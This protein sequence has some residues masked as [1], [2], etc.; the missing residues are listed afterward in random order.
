[1]SMTDPFVPAPLGDESGTIPAADPGRG[2]PDTSEGFGVAGEE[3]DIAEPD[4]AEPD[5][6]GSGDARAEVDP[7]LGPLGS[8]GDAADPPFR[9]P[10]PAQTRRPTA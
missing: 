10:D 3:P 1:M 7:A 8:A 4:V 9:T 2:A 5:A 6:A